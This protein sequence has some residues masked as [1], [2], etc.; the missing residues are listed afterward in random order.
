MNIADIDTSAVKGFLDR[1]EALCLHRVAQMA[2]KKGNC[3]EIGS[4]CGKSAVYIGLACRENG[5]K[6]YS[7]DH[8]RG[9][10]EQQLGEAYYDPE[11]YDAAQCCIN[12]LP[13]FLTTLES[14]S[15][16]DSVIP[17]V[18]DSVSVAKSWNEALALV[19]IDGGHSFADTYNDYNAWAC[20]VMPGGYLAIHDIFATATEGGQ[21]P[22]WI[23]QAALA[24]GLFLLVEQVKTLAILQR[25]PL[26]IVP[27]AMLMRFQD[28]A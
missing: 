4:Y 16:V 5:A 27:E 19:F 1:E 3:L 14:F 10:A 20:C 7:I 25:T 9:S 15:L 26:G 18:G 17:I 11:L 28:F 23:L 12:T 2:G 22:R 6:L 8:H 21:S 13:H 24:S